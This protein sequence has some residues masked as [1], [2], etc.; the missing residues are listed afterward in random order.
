M[1]VLKPK[2]WM[3]NKQHNLKSGKANIR[4]RDSKEKSNTGNPR[5][6][7]GLITNNFVIEYVDVVISWIKSKE[8]RK[9]KKETK[10]R[11]QKNAK[12]K[13]KKEERKKRTRER[14]RERERETEKEKLKKGEAT[15]GSGENKQKVPLVEKLFFCAMKSKERKRKKELN[16]K[17]NK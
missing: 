8:Y 14:K 5:K 2:R 12:K 10:G 11:N 17:E 13:D 3:L 4:K 7:K 9:T 16:K 1:F 6:E 15:K